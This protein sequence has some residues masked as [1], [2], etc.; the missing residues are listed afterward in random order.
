MGNVCC[1]AFD[2][3]LVNMGGQFRDLGDRGRCHSQDPA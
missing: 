2:F 1:V 3:V